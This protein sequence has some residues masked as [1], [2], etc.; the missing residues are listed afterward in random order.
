MTPTPEKDPYAIHELIERV[1]N[2]LIDDR[3]LGAILHIMDDY[4]LDPNAV[5]EAYEAER[6]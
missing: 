1:D 3:P 2:E 4:D 6:G 5:E